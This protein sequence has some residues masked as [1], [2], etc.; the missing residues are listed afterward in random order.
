MILVELGLVN[1][2]AYQQSNIRLIGTKL[3]LIYRQ[4]DTGS[5][6]NRVKKIDTVPV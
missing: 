2:T 6:Y 3:Q 5:V 1:L 4:A